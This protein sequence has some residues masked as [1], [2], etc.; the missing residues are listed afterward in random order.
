VSVNPVSGA[1]SL[2]SEET[3][4]SLRDAIVT[5]KLQPNERLV[6]AALAES[7]GSGRAAVRTALVRL[8][9]ERLVQREHNRGARV[10]LV[11]VEEAVEILEV[12]SFLESLI[13]RRAAERLTEEDAEDL[14]ADLEQLRACVEEGN[15]LA[16]S[17]ANAA[18]H[19]RIVAIAR[20]ETAERVIS[21]LHS[22]MVR[23]QYR[24]ILIPGRSTNSFPEHHA[25][26]EAILRRDGDAAEQ[27]M[28]RHL[29]NVAE[30]LRSS[31]VAAW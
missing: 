25:I 5:G 13:A 22:Q 3:Y 10:R 18:F 7:L 4:V 21:S 16:A 29:S 17:D 23:F 8:E 20:H 26:A 31:P 24:T 19:R 2:S 1:E 9:Q 30:A 15:L 28:R 11:P 14:R 12:R 27:A 6:E